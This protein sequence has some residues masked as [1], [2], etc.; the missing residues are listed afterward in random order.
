M[1]RLGY[2]PDNINTSKGPG[3]QS[4]P[5]RYPFH[6][7]E[8][9]EK[10]FRNSSGL[11]IVMEVAVDGRDIKVYE[12]LVYLK[13]S[14]WRLKE[15]L[16]STGFDYDD[17]PD[18]EDILGAEG[19]ADFKLGP[20]KDNDRRYLEVDHFLEQG[21]Q[22]TGPSG[23]GSAGAGSQP[24][25]PSR[26]RGRGESQGSKSSGGGRRRRRQRDDD[27]PPREDGGK[28]GTM[29]GGGATDPPNDDAD[30]DADELGLDDSGVPF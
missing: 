14:Q 1:G 20:K 28:R 4:Q 18:V 26:R 17:P 15:F 24:P 23:K 30:R 16:E 2:D 6:V 21:T 12:N 8:A 19:V 7:V 27:P 3:K 9:N 29:L 10:D 25:L 13:Q 5:G 11:R 22:A